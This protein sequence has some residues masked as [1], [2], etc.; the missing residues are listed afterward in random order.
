MLRP[1]RRQG[2]MHGS[3]ARREQCAEPAGVHIY[4]TA[5]AKFT[6]PTSVCLAPAGLRV[7]ISS[8]RYDGGKQKAYSTRRA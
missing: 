7:M 5:R 3:H 4:G 6:E 2:Y 1:D 8:P